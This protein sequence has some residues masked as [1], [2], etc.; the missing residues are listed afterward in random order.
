LKVSI[1]IF[2]LSMRAVGS[3]VA[4]ENVAAT[5]RI[6]TAAE[7]ATVTDQIEDTI[8]EAS[9]ASEGRDSSIGLAEQPALLRDDGEASHSVAQSFNLDYGNNQI[10][11]RAIDERIIDRLASFDS[12][13][14]GRS[15]RYSVSFDLENEDSDWNFEVTVT[16]EF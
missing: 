15:A 11:E 1:Y 14:G 12:S 16:M 4:Q 10:A 8:S 5:S 6:S 3:V 7:A 9:S 13:D 2:V